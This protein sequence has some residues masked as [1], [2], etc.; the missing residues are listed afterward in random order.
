MISRRRLAALVR[1]QDRSSSAG[2]AIGTTTLASRDG[3]PGT[4]TATGSDDLA[5]IQVRPGV[6]ALEERVQHRHAGRR[7]VLLEPLGVLRP[8]GVVMRERRARVDERLLDR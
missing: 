3:F 1:V 2:V 5:R 4:A 6:R 8:D 7:D